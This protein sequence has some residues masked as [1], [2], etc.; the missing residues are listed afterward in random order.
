MLLDN[1]FPEKCLYC[2]KYGK[3]ICDS[4]YKKL[5]NEYIFRKVYNDYFDYIICCSY[6]RGDIKKQ[7]HN[8]KFHEQSY[9]Y[10]YLIEICLLNNK[11]YNFLRNFDLITYI[12]MNYNK[13]LKRGY[14]Q[15][16]L[17]AKELGRK[18]NIEVIKTLKKPLQLKVQSTL[19]EKEREKNVK[20]AFE[21]IGK[22]ENIKNKKIILVDDII[23]TGST[24]RICSK[25]LKRFQPQKICILAIAKTYKNS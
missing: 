18:L 7:I 20:N 19:S 22:E 5:N 10:K 13:Q 23:T 17:L 11:I 16:E 15:S 25:I 2:K 3:Y 9:L 1:L 6:Y 24:V 12:P 8:F 14:N 4:C 21:F